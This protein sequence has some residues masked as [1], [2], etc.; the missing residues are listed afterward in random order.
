MK[1]RKMRKRN[2]KKDFLGCSEQPL[3]QKILITLC[4][5]LYK[6][7][8][9]CFLLLILFAYMVIIE[10]AFRKV[11]EWYEVILIFAAVIYVGHIIFLMKYNRIRVRG[12]VYRDS[13]ISKMVYYWENIPN[14]IYYF[15]YSLLVSC[16]ILLVIYETIILPDKVVGILWS[17][18][19]V[20]YLIL[21]LKFLIDKSWLDIILIIFLII[22]WYFNGEDISE[23]FRTHH[24]DRYK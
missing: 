10:L 13:I 6:I 21:T 22:Y 3:W 5:W 19:P 4:I 16:A 14:Y 18:I 12:K 20:F 23:Y 15:I 1:K 2:A 24:V 11:T 7:V 8:Q 17:I 9:V